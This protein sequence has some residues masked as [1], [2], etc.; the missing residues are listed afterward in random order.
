MESDLIN[1]LIP[2]IEAHFR[3]VPDQAHRAI[4]GLSAG[5]Y[6]AAN[7]ALRH[8]GEFGV[9]LV[10]GGDLQPEV[11]AFGANQAAL[12]ANDP[13]RLALGPKPDHAS[14]FF[15]GWGASDSL[16]SENSLFAQRLRARGY[17]VAMDVVP[18]AHTWDVWR[19][20]LL[21][22]LDQMGGL[23]GKPTPP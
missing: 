10:L 15:V 2:S 20:L 22:S 18:G 13:L 12:I 14:S 6:G 19:R 23:L 8:P 16:R 11:T 9:A 5:G 3:V 7:L 1:D 17:D 21:A 4:G